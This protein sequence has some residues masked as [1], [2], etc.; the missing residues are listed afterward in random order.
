MIFQN[1]FVDGTAAIVAMVEIDNDRI[2]ISNS[3]DQRAVLCRGEM[4][5][6]L[7][8][9]HKP[10][11]PNELLR[12]QGCGG[13]VTENKRVDGVLALSRA[14]GDNDLQPHVT[15]EPELF[16]VETVPDDKFLILAC[17]GLWDVV[18]NQQAVDI[19]L[20]C[21]DAVSA[22]TALRDI[23]NSLGSLDNISVIVYF[24]DFSLNSRGRKTSKYTDSVRTSK[25]QT[26]H[27]RVNTVEQNETE[28]PTS[29]DNS[30]HL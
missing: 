10:D 30:S 4:A 15:Y 12:I 20:G 5:I 21:D 1:N 11:D 25:S 13:Y 6:Q 8:F 26:K 7:T 28:T 24:F 16:F 29:L 17:D 9:D 18:T 22:A 19:V 14:L 23:A 3:G 27:P 2:I